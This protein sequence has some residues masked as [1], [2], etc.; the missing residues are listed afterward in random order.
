MGMLS[1]RAVYSYAHVWVITNGLSCNMEQYWRLFSVMHH[2]DTLHVEVAY[3][4]NNV[5]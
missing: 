3:T 2:W 1:Y 4:C 5:K